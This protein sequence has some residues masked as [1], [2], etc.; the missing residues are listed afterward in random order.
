M[1]GAGTAQAVAYQSP[2]VRGF[3]DHGWGLSLL[4]GV[5]LQTPRGLASL[6]TQCQFGKGMNK[7]KTKFPLKGTMGRQRE[8]VIC[9]K[10]L[11]FPLS[12]KI[13]LEFS[14]EQWGFLVQ[15]TFQRVLK[16]TSVNFLC[17][18]STPHPSFKTLLLLPNHVIWWFS[19]SQFLLS[20][21][22]AVGHSLDL[23][24]KELH[25]RHRNGHSTQAGLIRIL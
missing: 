9:Y 7:R 13:E 14:R 5:W 22:V 8:K 19:Q 12:P 16:K 3:S 24:I 23:P 11:V 25:F 4:V 17:L 6:T 10:D 21:E 1:I 2:V 18:S 15:V 20:L